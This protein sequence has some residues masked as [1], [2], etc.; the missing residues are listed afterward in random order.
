MTRTTRMVLAAGALLAGVSLAA[1][2][3]A[4]TADTHATLS[5][6]RTRLPLPEPQFEGTIGTTYLDSKAAWPKLPTPPEG[7]PNLVI[8]LLDDVGFGQTSTFGGSVPTPNL[9][10]LAA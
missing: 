9:D 4:Q 5:L 8:I 7:A 6:D 2:A 1:L 3:Q 10:K